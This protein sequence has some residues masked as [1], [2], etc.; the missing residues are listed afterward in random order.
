MGTVVASNWLV[1]DALAAN[2]I[3]Y[4]AGETVALTC[5]SGEDSVGERVAVKAGGCARDGKVALRSVAVAGVELH[6][7]VVR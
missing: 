7:E 3:P 5:L 2:G 6:V 1:T 4:E